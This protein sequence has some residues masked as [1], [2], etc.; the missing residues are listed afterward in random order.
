MCS[1]TASQKVPRDVP[2][3]VSQT[4]GRIASLYTRKAQPD[5]LWSRRTTGATLWFRRRESPAGRIAHSLVD[6]PLEAP[7]V[8]VFAYVEV[9]FAVHREGMWHVERPPKDPLLPD[10]VDDL[11]CF[12]QKNPNVVVGTVDHVQEALIRR[13]CDSRGRPSEQRS[14]GNESFPH[15]RTVFPKNLYA[16]VDAVGDIHQAVFR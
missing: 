7:T 4:G 10:V 6:K 9:T 16:V 5:A 11:E 13:E 8:K 3:T 15:K 1:E 2:F 14:R 12:A